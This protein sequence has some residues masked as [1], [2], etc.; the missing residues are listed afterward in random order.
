MNNREAPFKIVSPFEPKGDQPRA[1]E[2]L[3]QGLSAGKRHQV[4]L[5]VTGSGKT[6]TM[7]NVIARANKPALIIAHNKT[8]AG[9]L[10][11]EFKELFPENAVEYFV[12]YYDYYQPE[13]YIPTSDTYIEKDS[14]INDDIDKLRHSATHSLQTRNDTVVVASVSCIYGL[15][16]PDAYS[17]MAVR[18]EKGQNVGR[19]NVTRKLIEIAYTRNDIDF[20]RGTFRARGDVL[21]IFPAYEDERAVRVEF[22]GDT[23]ETLWDIDPLLG[24]KI[25]RLDRAAL[26]PSSHYVTPADMMQ[27]ALKAVEKELIEQVTAFKSKGMLLEAQRIEQRTRYDV[28]MLQEMGFCSGIE[29]YSRHLTGRLPGEPPYTL[30]DYFPRD[31]LLFIDESHQTVPQLHAMYLGDRTRKETLVRYGFRLPSAMDN[32]PLSFE[33]FERRAPQAIYVSATPADYELRKSGGVVVEQV[34]RPTGLV[35]PALEVLPASHQVDHLIG[36]IRKHTAQGDRVLITT[37]TKR[38]AEELTEYLRNIG[39]RVRYLHSDVETL[40]RMD[41]IRDLRKG[42]YDVLIGINLLREGLDIP[43]VSLV[44]ILDADKE[45]FLRSGRSLIQTVGRAARHVR[46]TALLYADRQTDSI[47]KTLDETGRRRNIQLAYNQEHGITPE[48]VRKNIR[49]I[50]DSVWE[51]DYYTIPTEKEILPVA[52]KRSY[53]GNP[54]KLGKAIEELRKQMREAAGRLQFEKAAEIRDKVK[55]LQKLELTLRENPHPY[56]PME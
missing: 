52:E 18:L 29:N 17:E 46:G 32:R 42:E 7:A 39:I 55:E 48:S 14:S 15:G 35:D 33:E 43:E 51:Q 9:Q 36:E 23:I 16:A 4:L 1:I 25:S 34:I 24:R 10:Y 41:L 56:S 45:G 19:E 26:Y 3:S 49:D 30:F 37:L 54:D 5:G 31:F 20:R 12:S 38:M 27:K 28:E 53:Y 40:E 6:F 44:A 8:L 21:E 11:N 22:F 47:K 13:A 2:E 50:R